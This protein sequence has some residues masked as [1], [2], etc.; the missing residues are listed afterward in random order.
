MYVLTLWARTDLKTN[1][2]SAA[3][4]M[5]CRLSVHSTLRTSVRSSST[6][7]VVEDVVLPYL[8]Q[9]LHR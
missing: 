7:V 3:Y 4:P 2:D 5:A 8:L 9:S 1:E 6:Y